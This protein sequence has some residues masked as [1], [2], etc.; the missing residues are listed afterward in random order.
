MLR[1]HWFLHIRRHSLSAISRAH[2]KT[3]VEAKLKTHARSTVTLMIDVVRGC[4]QAAVEDKIIEANPAAK[5]GKLFPVRKAAPKR[6]M[7]PAV[8]ALVL[9]ELRH[10]MS[11]IYGPAFVLART[12]LRLGEVFLSG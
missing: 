6:T 3:V 4:L 8:I 9:G 11:T 12:G 1:V 7:A 2:L 10:Q 5:L